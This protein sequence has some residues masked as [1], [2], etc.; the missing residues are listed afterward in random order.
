MSKKI[1]EIEISRIKQSENSRVKYHREDLHELISSLRTN[2]L[3]Q[4][5]GIHPD[6]DDHSHFH[7]VYGNRR[8]LAAEKLGWKTIPAIIL[9]DV[10]EQDF[11]IKNLTENVQRKNLSLPEEGRYFIMLRD[12]MHLTTEEIAARIGLSKTHILN[13]MNAFQVIPKE[14][15]KDV[16]K[17]V[18]GLSMKGHIPAGAAINIVHNARNLKKEEISTLL[19]KVK[20]GELN[21]RK[22]GQITRLI[23]TGMPVKKAIS[24]VEQMRTIG[25]HVPLRLKLIDRLEKKYDKPIYEII[26]DYIKN[27]QEL[28]IEEFDLADQ[29]PPEFKKTQERIRKR[30]GPDKRETLTLES[31]EESA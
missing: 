10:S 27:I 29:S 21:A 19:D 5:I 22:V 8:F 30:Y 11:L 7:I 31:E 6:P 20:S 4:P 25:I 23:R 17:S 1:E 28:E 3:L 13:A 12:E 15:R 24:K 14:Y 9:S 18:T 2:G 26:Y 16:R